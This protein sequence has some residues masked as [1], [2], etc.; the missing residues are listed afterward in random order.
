MSCKACAFVVDDVLHP[1]N[2]RRDFI[3]LESDGGSWYVVI[4]EA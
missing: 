1:L 2:V 4:G 3:V